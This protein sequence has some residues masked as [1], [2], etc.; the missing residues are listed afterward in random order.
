MCAE[1]KC[2]KRMPVLDLC[3]CRFIQTMKH[4]QTGI[5]AFV[6]IKGGSGKTTLCACLG[7]EMTKRG[8]NVLLVDADPQGSLTAWHSNGEQMQSIQLIT[9]PSEKVAKKALEASKTHLVLI[10]TA[11]FANRATIDIANIADTL[12]IPCRASGIDAR[13]ALKTIEIAQAINAE[14]E[15]KARLKVVMTATNRSAIVSHIRNEMTGAGAEVLGCEV[16]QR[17]IYP[18]CEL[19]GTAP[20]FIGKSA[21]K[22]NDEMSALATELLR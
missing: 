22:A 17:S 13:S 11:G 10:D 20:C 3:K 6:T 8:V 16:G 5:I 19:S 18:E 15:S 9:E 21:Q 12:L 14:R 7:A 1:P 2:L 4:K